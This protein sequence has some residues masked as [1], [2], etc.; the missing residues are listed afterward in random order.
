ML[1]RRIRSLL[2]A[3]AVRPDLLRKMPATGADAMVIDLEDATPSDAKATAREELRSAVA[4][5]SGT[6]P[7]CARINDPSTPWHHDDLDSL[8]EGLD[9]IVV[10]KVET[11]QGLDAL[12]RALEARGL[13]V[14]V[15]GG[16]ETAL[17]VADARALLSHPV[18]A[19]GYFGA[20]DFIADMG[21]VRTHS[22]HEVASAR[23]QVALAGRVARISMIDMI[24]ADFTDDARCRRECEE[25]REIG[26]AG[27]LCIHPA[28]VAIAN[29]AFTPSI[30]EVE[31]ARRLLAAYEDAKAK[32]IASV[33]FE[34]QM[35]DEP[36]AAQARTVIALAEG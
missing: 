1:P 36:V 25:A 18:I 5:L 19:A 24:T 10:P 11:V 23:S 34:G 2:F 30:E 12:E 28:Q 20:E 33:A 4:D 26:Y 31:R 21:G 22:N 9:A 7:I 32:G 15:V 8:P 14:P 35:V 3:P 17:G 27:K 16:I 13:D 6:I 29:E